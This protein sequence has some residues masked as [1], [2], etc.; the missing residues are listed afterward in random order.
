MSDQSPSSNQPFSERA[1]FLMGNPDREE[2]RGL[3]VLSIGRCDRESIEPLARRVDALGVLELS[4]SADAPMESHPEAINAGIDGAK[5]HWV[6]IV[7]TGEIITDALADEIVASAIEPPLSWGFRIR[8]DLLYGGRPLSLRRRDRGEIRLIHRRHA[9]FDRRAPGSEIKVQGTVLRMKQ[10][11]RRVLFDSAGAHRDFLSRAAVP[12]SAL[13]R[14]LLFSRRAL[15]T[16][17]LWR[18][19]NALRY[20]WIESGYDREVDTLRSGHP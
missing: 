1:G 16:G 13:R 8:T 12:Q 3:T 18:S 9:K 6:L 5:S 14:V 19:Y 11:F 10:R 15:E 2:S 17:A 4:I 20:L 7:R